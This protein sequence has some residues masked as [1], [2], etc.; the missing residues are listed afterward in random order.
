MLGLCFCAR[1][2]SSCGKRG[3]LFIA[4]RGPLTIVA[5]LVAEHRLQTRRL[6]SCGSRAQLL[7]GMWD[8]PRPGLESVSPALAGRFSTTTPPGKPPWL[9]LNEFLTE[10]RDHSFTSILWS[11]PELQPLLGLPPPRPAPFSICQTFLCLNPQSGSWLIEFAPP[12]H[13]CGFQ[14]PAL[15]HDRTKA[16]FT[17]LFLPSVKIPPS[18]PGCGNVRGAWWVPEQGWWHTHV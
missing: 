11:S 3:P 4:V 7:R 1:A 2:S 18:M 14:V 9:A 10:W 5:S 16:L 17:W 12:F 8:L 6:S 13:L 15:L